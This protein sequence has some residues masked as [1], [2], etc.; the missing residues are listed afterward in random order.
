MSRTAPMTAP[1]RADGRLGLA[2]LVI[3]TAQ[4]MMVL[5]DTV[6]NVALPSIQAQFDMSE[7]A[8]PWVINAYV[9]AFGGLLLFGGRVGDLYGRIRVLRL[10]LVVFTAASLAGGL[11]PSSELLIAARGVQG[12]GAA[13]VAPNALALIATTFP[14]GRARNRA[15][16]V[17]GAMSALGITGGVL[18]GGLLTGALSWRWVLLINIPIGL[19]VLAGTRILVAGERHTGRLDTLGAVTGTAGFTALA[20]GFTRAGEH[21]WTDSITLTAFGAAVATLVL[22]VVRQARS[23]DPLLPLRLLADRNR[24][25]AYLTVLFIGGGLMGTFYLATLFMQQVLQLGPLRA[26]VAA[27]PFGLGI[28]LAS[29][30]ASK[31]AEKLPP[32]A[33]AVPGLLLAAAGM[34]WLSALPVDAGYWTDLLVPLFLTSAGLGLAFVPMTLTVVHDVDPRETGVASALMNTAQQIGA[35]IGLAVLTTVSAT[36]AATQLPGAATALHTARAGGD[37]DL[38]ARAQQA[39]SHGYTTAYLAAAALLV[40]AAAITAV[41]VNTRHRQRSSAEAGNHAG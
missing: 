29:G 35:A 3:A 1:P 26:G 17:Y 30:V 7:S 41:G 28:I 12:L 14:A 32:R 10:G 13:L 36:A 33:I 38:V 2:L 9:L 25:S 11:A 4:L 39:L 19:A 22:F 6:A 34:F 20:Y 24:S 16:A 21:G 18:L 27:L 8:L 37:D 31:L 15:M 23:R 40:V 5:D